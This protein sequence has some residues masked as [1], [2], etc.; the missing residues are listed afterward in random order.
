MLLPGTSLLVYEMA[1]ALY[2]AVA[3]NSAERVA[4]EL[5]LVDVQMIGAAGRLFIAGEHVYKLKKPVDLGFLD[6]STPGRRLHM[7]RAEV[8]LNRRLAP[9]VYFAAN[10]GF[11]QF[12][13]SFFA[14][15]WS[16]P[17]AA[18]KLPGK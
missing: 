8:D 10:A 3:A 4:P 9:D 16:F 18:T 5:T 6:Y 12:A 15:I 1:P 14:T 2:A 17:S 13:F 11:V 7:C